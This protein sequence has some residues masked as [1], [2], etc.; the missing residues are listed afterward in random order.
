MAKRKGQIPKAESNGK[1][2]KK[3]TLREKLPYGVPRRPPGRVPLQFWKDSGFS[4]IPSSDREGKAALDAK[5]YVCSLV[6]AAEYRELLAAGR[7]CSDV[8]TIIFQNSD[9]EGHIE[10]QITHTYGTV[11]KYVQLYRRFFIT[12]MEKLESGE[13]RVVPRTRGDAGKGNGA[14]L[15]SGILEKQADQL[16]KGLPELEIM[17]EILLIQRERI[18]EQRA[19]EADMTFPMPNLYK[20]MDVA[21]KMASEITNLKADLGFTGYMRVPKQ[22]AVTSTMDASPRLLQA[23]TEEEKKNLKDFGDVVVELIEK[24]G[25]HQALKV[26]K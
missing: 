25:V 17:E 16:N 21:N 24:E 15:Y 20:E 13:F 1:P 7:K 14:N 23:M 12:A 2:N 5:N 18:V 6:G 4:T 22:L 19:K 8:A 26:K 9:A 3:A 11:Y 10:G